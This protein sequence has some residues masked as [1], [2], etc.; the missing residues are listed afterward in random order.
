MVNPYERVL[1]DDAVRKLQ[2]HNLSERTYDIAR[3]TIKPLPFPTSYPYL[4]FE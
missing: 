3:W 1:N 2:S 4:K